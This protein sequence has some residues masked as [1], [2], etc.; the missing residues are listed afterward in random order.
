MG[1]RWTMVSGVL[2]VASFVLGIV[3]FAATQTV[4]GRDWI[5]L[6]IG[7]VF[8]GTLASFLVG[9][10]MLSDRQR[11]LIGA[12]KAVL[13]RRLKMVAALPTRQESILDQINRISD[14]DQEIARAE[15]RIE[16]HALEARGL[17]W[18]HRDDEAAIARGESEA[19]KRAVESL[20]A[21]R[22]ILM[23]QLADLRS[24]TDEEF[25]KEQART[26]GLVQG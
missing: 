10:V 12:E 15:A 3:F 24:A 26:W 7:A 14:L 9:W 17:G 20:N 21:R 16:S 2:T 6:A 11:R 25:A 1:A 8:G 5:V 4:V 23:D 19:A 13:A 18:Q 22:E